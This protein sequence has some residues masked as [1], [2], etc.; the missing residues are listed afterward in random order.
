MDADRARDARKYKK[1]RLNKGVEEVGNLQK[2]QV[3]SV[4]QYLF[5]NQSPLLNGGTPKKS[6][7][8]EKL[9]GPAIDS[10]LTKE[11]AKVQAS[12]VVRINKYNPL[13]SL[14]KRT[15]SRQRL[16]ATPGTSGQTENLKPEDETAVTTI[17]TTTHS[18]VTSKQPIGGIL[19]PLPNASKHLGKS[20]PKLTNGRKLDRFNL[21]KGKMMDYDD[22]K[23]EL[24]LTNLKKL[25]NV[26]GE[27]T[28]N[29][30]FIKTFSK[31]QP[32]FSEGKT[33][34]NQDMVVAKL[35]IKES[36]NAAL[37]AVFDG[38]GAFG[39][40]VSGFLKEHV[41]GSFFLF[42]NLWR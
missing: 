35:S 6:K 7:K 38:H 14:D 34:T 41:V 8:F 20:L 4:L 42:Q 13:P 27:G 3:P 31:T 9:G 28:N 10:E 23:E 26:A 40:K 12:G 19:R 11:K 16:A 39:H 18:Q 30:L 32:G 33:K 22:G 25:D 24:Q 17:T 5:D 29:S 1:P 2:K 37:F 21:A 36:Q 15:V